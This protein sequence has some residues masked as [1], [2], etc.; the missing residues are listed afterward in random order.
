MKAYRTLD[1]ALLT[2]FQHSGK[3]FSQS[4][5][6]QRHSAYVAG[7]G[8][9]G[10][11]EDGML[12]EAFRE[13]STPVLTLIYTKYAPIIAGFLA[14]GFSFQSKGGTAWFKGFREP[15]DLE[16]CLQETF[17]RAFA[18]PARRSYNGVTSYLNYL[19]AIARNIVIDESRRRDPVLDTRT[20]ELGEPPQPVKKTADFEVGRPPGIPQGTE[21]DFTAVFGFINLLLQPDTGYRWQLEINGDPSGHASFRTRPGQA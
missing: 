14:R 13:G 21:L 20:V 6:G 10:L 16:N 4:L 18:E 12:L 15:Y 11:T 7:S 3:V 1:P 8:R 5:A 17:A 2:E 9:G 19:L